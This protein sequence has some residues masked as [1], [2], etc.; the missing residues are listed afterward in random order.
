MHSHSR[1]NSDLQ[2]NNVTE[3][4][5][6]SP[7]TLAHTFSATLL[8]IE[9]VTVQ[10]EAIRQPSLP[11]IVLTG[12]PNEVVKESTER[13]R[14]CLAG[15]GFLVPRDRIVV[16]LLPAEVRKQGSQMDLA[17]AL[18]VLAVE[19]YLEGATLK[20]RAFL[21]EL[22]LNGQL[23]RAS[24]ALALAQAL[25]LVPG[26]EVLIVPEENA[27]ELS[28]IGDTRIH[29]AAHIGEVIDSLRLK[30]VLRPVADG[31]P[32]PTENDHRD[33]LTWAPPCSGQQLAKRA[34]QIA[35]SGHH[36][37]LLVGSPGVGKSLLARLA[38]LLAPPLLREEWLDVVKTHWRQ[39]TPAYGRIPFRSP[40][41]SIS[42]SAFLG[43]GTGQVYPGEVSL[44]HHGILFM[45][46]LPEFRR[47]IL[48]GLR[49]P[50]ESGEIDLSRVGLSVRLPARFLLVAAMNPC[51][52]GY[53]LS[54]Q[55]PCRC[56]SEA[57]RRYQR[58]LS[59]PIFDRLDMCV[60]LDEP[61]HHA[62][63]FQFKESPCE[64]EPL[65]HSIG[66][67]RKRQ[68]ARYCPTPMANGYAIPSAF[69]LSFMLQDDVA[70]YVE[71][72][73]NEKRL[74]HRGLQKWFRLARTVADLDN[75]DALTK[76]DFMETD[77]LRCDRFI[78]EP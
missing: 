62:S 25:L 34:L 75:R 60:I 67:A 8:G 65:C 30:K 10:V 4:T 23:K 78:F 53:A 41:H 39:K 68:Q 9:G 21:G 59:G 77:L 27:R 5:G 36:H 44:A 66:E 17:I 12:L 37:L 22:A 55:L 63:Q 47:D 50:L 74:S 61:L 24:G 58:R 31:G 15:V 20:R 70:Q 2:G 40:H 29:S 26:L 18:S 72:V 45:D 64:Y 38:P 19:G 13:V 3:G 69:P 42:A 56:T 49:E 7:P 71:S 11:K 57:K 16:Q 51:P 48:E 43:G 54:S 32:T 6:H 28:L 35:L 46:E 76:E 14:G 33:D 1:K 52:C 73:A